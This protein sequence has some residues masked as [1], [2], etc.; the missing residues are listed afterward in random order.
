MKHLTFGITDTR[1]KES[2]LQTLI[3]GSD[4]NDLVQCIRLISLYV[5]IYKKHY[6]ELPSEFYE[7]IFMP[8][9]AGK[10]SADV[11]EKGLGE[12]IAMLDMVIKTS[13]RTLPDHKGKVTIN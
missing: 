2:A 3:D 12:A 8:E 11:F 1:D 9:D 10:S 4:K 5:S 7:D 13:P 6:G